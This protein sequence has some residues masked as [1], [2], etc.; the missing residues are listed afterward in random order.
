MATIAVSGQSRLHRLREHLDVGSGVMPYFLVAPALLLIAVV[1]IYPIID[2]IRL[3]FL[4]NPLVPTGNNFVGL[5]NYVEAFRDP[6]FLG[7][8][9]ATL[10]FSV[11][12]V[13]FELLVGF[14]IAL[15]INKTFPGRGLVRAAILIPWAFP[16][17]VS[18]QI[19]NLMYNTNT[20]I[21]TYMLQG[22]HVLAPGD[23]LL[24]T[25]AGIMTAMVLTDVW[26]TAPF[27]ALLILAGLQV[28]PNE[29]YE[30]A[31]V[32]GSTRFQQFWTITLPMLKN[33]LLIALL[34]RT[35]DAVR[36]FDLAYVLAGHQLQTIA[37]Y[38]YLRMFAGTASDFPVGIA[39]AIVLFIFGIL[40]SALFV[41][42]MR[43]IVRQ[44]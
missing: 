15:L 24:R 26:K 14:G 35:L 4:E 33:A 39:T 40:I 27:M 6:V 42:Q 8:I 11:I 7:S 28:I 30:A 2:A 1:A 38:S 17:V 3:S 19:W 43:G 22:L 12:S 16:T 5:N 31:S 36:I 32:D 13:T 18:A 29:L 34:F 23:S 9:G 44:E 41:S 20:G 21:I 37:M 10:I 25:N